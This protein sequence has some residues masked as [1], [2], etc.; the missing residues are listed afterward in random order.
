[1]AGFCDAAAG[2]IEKAPRRFNP[3]EKPA[4]ILRKRAYDSDP[5]MAS[6]LRATETPPSS[7]TGLRD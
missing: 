7:Q 4:D 2:K 6:G 5:T 1:L 3:M